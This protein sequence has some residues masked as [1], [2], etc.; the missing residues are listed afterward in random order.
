MRRTRFALFTA[1]ALLAAASSHG[2]V[3]PG[4]VVV[5]GSTVATATDAD[6][7]RINMGGVAL[8]RSRSLRFTHVSQVRGPDA[9]LDADALTF[10]TPL[11][12]G[13]SMSLGLTWM[14]PQVTGPLGASGHLVTGELGLAY[15]LSRLMGLGARLRVMGASGTGQLAPLGNGAASVD[16]GFAWRP[17]PQL[18]F[19]LTATNL[20]GPRLPALGLDRSATLGIGVRPTGDDALTLGFDGGV[21][22]DG[23]PF[24]RAGVRLAVPYVGEL[25][26][27]GFYDPSAQAWRVGAGLEVRFSEW[28]LG[29]GA[30]FG[31]APPGTEAPLGFYASGRLD[32]ERDRGLPEPSVL[33]TLRPDDLSPAS[34]THLVVR[35]E[36]MRRDPAVRAVLFA[37]RGEI[38]GL[39]NAEELRAEFARL[40]ASGRTVAC[41]LTSASGAAYYACSAA[42]SIAMDPSSALRLAGIQSGSFFLGDALREVGVRTQFVR[43]GAWKSAPEQFTRG[44]STPEALAQENQLLD[45]L[46]ETLSAGIAQGRGVSV[47][48]ARAVIEAGPYTASEALAANLVDRVATRTAT[49]SALARTLGV[50][51]VDGE[52]YAPPRARRWGPGPA[53]AVLRIDGDIVDGESVDLPIPL[54]GV[55]L[56]GERTINQVIDAVAADP[57]YGAIVLRVDSPG[58]SAV[59]SEMIWR[60]VARAAQRKPVVV[61]MGRSAASGGYYV[62]APGREIFANPSTLT[63]SIGIFSGKADLG[64]L[65]SQLHVGIELLR[66]GPH[67]DMESIF[68]PYTD[69]ELRIEERLIQ[70]SY[71]LFV[72]RVAVGRHMTP[73]AVNA[74][75]EGRVF[76]GTR[77]QRVGLVDRLGGLADA[78]DRARDLGH[79]GPDC[80][81]VELPQ[82][83]GG[84]LATLTSLLLGSTGAAPMARLTANSE[85]RNALSWLF[86]LAWT[87]QGQAMAMTEWPVMAP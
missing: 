66:R 72:R 46:Y 5:P 10:A 27:E 39:A 19:G 83:Q 51:A 87:G 78:L 60:A 54:V 32:E 85:L 45:D 44:H 41:H 26:A 6:T 73:A 82:S 37:P 48:R 50:S 43:I 61:S 65:L 67:A 68:R 53:V 25:R 35:L 21:S 56:V 36:R 11:A 14:R 3:L 70:E 31:S 9:G 49:E 29:G 4:E 76:S 84:L 59:A 77:A 20:L 80:D 30:F 47:E 52:D 57:R 74:V 38:G 7:A 16:L 42:S 2:Q 64:Q 71:N 34:I 58:G 40:R 17:L 33:V 18:A 23:N 22:Q 75:G 63:G 81:V 55:H 79:L 13:L 12:F 24:V 8:L 28:A 1:A 62:A 86:T 15:A 69:E